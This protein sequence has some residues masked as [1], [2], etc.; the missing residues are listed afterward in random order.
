MD[1]T[2]DFWDLE[3]L[4]MELID[5]AKLMTTVTVQQIVSFTPSTLCLTS[6]SVT[7]ENLCV[8]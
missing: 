2:V 6:G 1:A 3:K 8:V 5:V 7:E 4:W